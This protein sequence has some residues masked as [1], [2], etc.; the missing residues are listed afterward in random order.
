MRSAIIIAL[1]L[2]TAPAHAE[3][4]FDNFLNGKISDTQKKQTT[5]QEETNKQLILLQKEMIDHLKEQTREQHSQI[6]G[7]QA[8]IS[9]LKDDVAQLK[10]SKPDS[11]LAKQ[12]QQIDDLRVHQEQQAQDAIFR[13]MD[14]KKRA[15]ESK[16]LRRWDQK[17]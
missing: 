13:E 12:Q 6:E 15:N 1:F 5:S 4:S 16:V 9:I 17:R 8:E 3:N 10:Q 2:F 11:K 14:A 7:M